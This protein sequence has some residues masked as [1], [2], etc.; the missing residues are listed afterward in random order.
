VPKR[1]GEIKIKSRKP[2]IFDD[3]SRNPDKIDAALDSLGLA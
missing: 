2:G 3:Y 1:G